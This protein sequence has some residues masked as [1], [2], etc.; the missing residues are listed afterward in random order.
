[1]SRIAK[2]VAHAAIDTAAKNIIA[3]RGDDKIISRA[4]V[5]KHAKT[6]VDSRNALKR[7]RTRGVFRL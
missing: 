3:A 4:D 1:M 7:R 2:K 6:I 5:A